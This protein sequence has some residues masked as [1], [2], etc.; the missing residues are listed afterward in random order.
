MHIVFKSK[1]L[2]SKFIEDHKISSENSIFINNKKKVS[3]LSGYD[4]GFWWVQNFSSMLPVML[5]NQIK[6]KKVLDLCAAPGGKSFQ[7]LSQ[8]KDVILNDKSKNLIGSSLILLTLFHT[9]RI[10]AM[11]NLNCENLN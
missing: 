2:V 10:L 1:E 8:N 4:E 6:N 9:G 5:F 11:S 7:I 3:D